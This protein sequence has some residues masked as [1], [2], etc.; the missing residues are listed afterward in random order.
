MSTVPPPLSGYYRALM[1]SYLLSAN[2]D[3]AGTVHAFATP[4]E[5]G[6]DSEERLWTAWGEVIRQAST[7]ASDD[8]TRLVDLVRSLRDRGIRPDPSKP[9]VIWGQ[10][11]WTGLPLLNSQMRE[12]WNWAAPPETSDYTWRNVNG[13]A[14]RLTVAGI[15]FSQLGLWTIRSALEETTEVSTVELM[16]AAEWFKY[17]SGPLRKWSEADRQFEGPDDPATAPGKLLVEEGFTTS[18]FSATRLAYWQRRIQQGSTQ[19]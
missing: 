18:G 7:R 13:L 1:R 8:Q 14:A 16:A 17:L 6:V 11:L 15:D 19:R 2:P 5:K 12:A 4:I 10:V 3:L 9:H